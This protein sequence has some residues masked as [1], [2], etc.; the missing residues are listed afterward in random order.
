[1]EEKL[2]IQT[3]EV[4]KYEFE[5]IIKDY[6]P[7]LYAQIRCIVLNHE[8][9]ND[10]LQNTFLKAW[11]ALPNFKG[12][13]GFTTWLYRIAINESLQHIRKEKFRKFFRLDS[14]KNASQLT[15]DSGSG[16]GEEL[17][18]EEALK[19]LSS[20]QRMIFGMRYLNETTYKEI[21]EVLHLAEGTVKS[22]YHQAYK[23]IEKY[24]IEQAG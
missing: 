2:G 6:S 20:Q 4:G 3:V 22:T 7:M 14:I 16:G 21:A 11:K 13:S 5:K 24:L 15:H 18:L 10:V 17:K 19:M 8:D 12:N 1:M 9:T 23:K